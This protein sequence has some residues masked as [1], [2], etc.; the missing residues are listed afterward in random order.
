MMTVIVNSLLAIH[1]QLLTD[2]QCI[3][4]I[5]QVVIMSYVAHVV[6]ETI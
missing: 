6:I 2:S 4:S 5:I 3:M 1:E